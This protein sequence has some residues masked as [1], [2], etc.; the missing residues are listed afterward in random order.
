LAAARRVA[1]GKGPQ[2]RGSGQEGSQQHAKNCAASVELD[3]QRTAFR[4]AKRTAVLPPLPIHRG[5]RAHDSA[6]AR[7]R[8]PGR[9]QRQQAPQKPKASAS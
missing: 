6:A 4:A 5:K 1:I 9:R 8:C 3:E 2:T 7:S